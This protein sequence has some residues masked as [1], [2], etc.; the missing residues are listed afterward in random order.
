MTHR[1]FFDRREGQLDGVVTLR[2][3]K[4]ELFK[5]LPA[6]S[7]QP[8]HLT[9]ATQW[10][11]GKGATPY[12]N[13]WMSTRQVPLQMEPKGTPFYMIGTNKGG[14][15]IYGSHGQRRTAIGLHLENN[16]PG[17]AGC[18][19]LRHDTP[20]TECMAWALFAY[21]DRLSKYEPFIEF[22]VL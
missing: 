1:L 5:Q 12:G 16:W 15:T 4:Q 11:R 19:V 17:S 14:S 6:R 13:H 9:K 20:E 7:G 18:I 8:G 22:I 3:D 2:N 21:L 10:V